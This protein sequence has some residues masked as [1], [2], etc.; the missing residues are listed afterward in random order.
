MIERVYSSVIKS[1]SISRLTVATDSEEIFNH[2]LSFGKVVMTSINHQSGTD[3][4]NEVARKY[5]YDYVINIQGDC[6]ASHHQIDLLVS[7]VDSETEIITL[8]KRIENKEEINNPNVVKVVLNHKK[9]AIYFSR[10]PIPYQSDIYYKHI[11]IYG[12][13]YDV[14][15]KI[16]KLALSNL[17]MSESLEQLRWIENGFK[18][19][20]IEVK[21]DI[22]SVD[23]PE[24][25]I[26]VREIYRNRHL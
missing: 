8:I 10:L 12:Y 21:Y 1:K 13:R 19:K 6:L 5:E 15:D 20:T 24:D 22:I 14:L 25:L 4:V 9:E 11:G 7:G 26:R 3:R 17:E 2:V 23:T 18:I 16:T